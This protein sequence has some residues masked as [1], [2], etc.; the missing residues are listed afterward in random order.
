MDA[1]VTDLHGP[2]EVWRN[3]SPTPNHWLLIRT[4]GTKSNRDGI[5]AKIKVTTPS[6]TLHSHVEH[7]GRV[8]RGLRPPGALRARR[9]RAS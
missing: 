6:E 2:I 9:R 8:R 3:V 4:V 7:R 5:G 1:V